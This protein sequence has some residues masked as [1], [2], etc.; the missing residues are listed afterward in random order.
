M[1]A[2]RQVSNLVT[3]QLKIMDGKTKPFNEMKHIILSKAVLLKLRDSLNIHLIVSL[4]TEKIS[5]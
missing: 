3:L 1:I 5:P 2:S 4:F